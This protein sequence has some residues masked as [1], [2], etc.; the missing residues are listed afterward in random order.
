MAAMGCGP[1]RL[2]GDERILELSRIELTQ[3]CVLEARMRVAAGARAAEDF[4][5]TCRPY[6]GATWSPPEGEP[7]SV[8]AANESKALHQALA[9]THGWERTVVA[10]QGVSR[11]REIE[12]AREQTLSELALDAER[13]RQ[14]ELVTDLAVKLHDAAATLRKNQ[15]EMHRCFDVSVG[16]AMRKALRFDFAPIKDQCALDAD[17]LEA[18][19][20][21][22]DKVRRE[23]AKAEEDPHDADPPAGPPLARP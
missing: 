10:S 23:L 9:I 3:A 1:L 13:R 16:E 19:V 5:S 18:Q 11:V 14:N 2:G 22:L 4:E 20:K 17:V 21:A 6:L 15:A 7:A 8:V 12:L